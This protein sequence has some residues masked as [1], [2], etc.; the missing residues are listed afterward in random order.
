ML[1]YRVDNEVGFSGVLPLIETSRCGRELLCRSSSQES[2]LELSSVSPVGD[3]LLV[4]KWQMQIQVKGDL[5]GCCKFPSTF[6]KFARKLTGYMK[7]AHFDNIFGHAHACRHRAT[8]LRWL[9]EMPQLVSISYTI[10]D[11]PSEKKHEG[12]ETVWNGLKCKPRTIGCTSIY[13]T[14]HWGAG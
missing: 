11:H 8:R 5:L 14:L 12:L 2:C 7:A 13:R 3:M 9:A 10:A 6:I 1:L 4:R